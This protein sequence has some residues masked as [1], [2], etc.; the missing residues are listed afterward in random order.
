MAT[1]YMVKCFVSTQ[2]VTVARKD[3]DLNPTCIKSVIGFHAV[4]S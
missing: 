4:C 1:T 3:V 2:Y